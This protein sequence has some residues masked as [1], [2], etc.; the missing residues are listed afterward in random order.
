MFAKSAKAESAA[1]AARTAQ[2]IPMVNLTED[3]LGYMAID[4]QAHI[5]GDIHTQGD[6]VVDGLVEGNVVAR[7][8]IVT[9][10]GRIQGKVTVQH[11]K[12]SGVLQPELHCKE[13]LEI[14]PTGQVKGKCT[15]GSLLVALGG[16]LL[17]EAAE[18]AMDVEADTKPAGAVSR[19][20]HSAP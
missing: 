9:A 6:V 2:V 4:S 10:N 7:K 18:F 19:L 1:P 8:V 13:V 14:A 12:V 17:G 3:P 11:A 5:K 15:Y 16:R 20:L